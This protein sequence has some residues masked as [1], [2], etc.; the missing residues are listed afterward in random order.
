M[1]LADQRRRQGLFALAHPRYSVRA[2]AQ[3]LGR[4]PSTISSELRR[5]A[6]TTPAAR[7][8]PAP[9]DAVRRQSSILMAS[10]SV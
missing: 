5:N 9:Y 4:T 6:H 3:V 2:M 1:N 8:V 7:L 10:C